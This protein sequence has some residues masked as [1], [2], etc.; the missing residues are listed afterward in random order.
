MTTTTQAVTLALHDAAWTAEEQDYLRHHAARI[1]YTVNLVQQLQRDH[2]ARTL[3]DVGPHLL[4]TAL[5]RLLPSKLAIS[6]LGWCN[7]RMAPPGVAQRHIPMDLNTCDSTAIACDERF[8]IIVFAETIEHLTIA[9]GVVL[10]ALAG[11]L[12]PTGTLVVMTPNAVS[13][14]KRLKMLAGRHPYEP[15]RDDRCNP[16][17][18]RESTMAELLAF[19]HQA[20]LQPRRHSHHDFQPHRHLPVR[21]W[22]GLV[23]TLREGLVVCFTRAA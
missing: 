9:P 6:T 16:G 23:P 1:A 13:L 11:L 17:H 10:R 15:L 2:G 20:G 4:T 8:D 19:G 5:H 21:L 18:F 22:A 3:L 12:S 7:P 14:V